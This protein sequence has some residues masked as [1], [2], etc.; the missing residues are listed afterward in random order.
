MHGLSSNWVIL[1]SFCAFVHLLKLFEQKKSERDLCSLV[2]IFGSYSLLHCEILCMIIQTFNCQN[3][4]SYI[5]LIILSTLLFF[6][7]FKQRSFFTSFRKPKENL[8]S[9]TDLMI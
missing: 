2:F 9:E 6:V 3:N 4:F 1:K 8:H 7:L 5:F